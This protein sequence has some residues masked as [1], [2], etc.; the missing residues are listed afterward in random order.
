MQTAIYSN[1]NTGLSLSDRN[2]PEGTYCEGREIDISNFPG[3]LSSGYPAVAITAPSGGL[4][5]V[6]DICPDTGT[7]NIYFIGSTKIWQMTNVIND[8]WAANFDGS[9]HAYYVV[10][11]MTQGSKLLIYSSM[12]SST[13]IPR[14]FYTYNTASNGYLGFY[15]LTG[16]P[17]TNDTFQTLNDKSA[18][19]DMV[20][21]Q[22]VLW[23]ADGQY[24]NKFDGRVTTDGTYT[25]QALDLGNGWQITKLITNDNYLLICAWRKSTTTNNT[26]SRIFYWDGNSQTYNYSVNISD[27]KIV[28]AINNNNE[29]LV[30]TEG[31]QL[32]SVV[33]RLNSSGNFDVVKNMVTP[34]AGSNVKFVGV[35]QNAIGIANNRIIIGSNYLVWSLGQD[36]S[37]S[38]YSVCIPWGFTTPVVS[39]IIS[40]IKLTGLYD[41]IYIG[42]SSYDGN[43]TTYYI[44]K[45]LYD[46]S[47]STRATYRGNYTDLPQKGVA[48]YVKFYFQKLVS[49]DSAT[50]SV[51]TDYG[52]SNSIQQDT[53]IISF[54]LDGAVTFKKFDLNQIE[55]HAFRPVVGFTGGSVKISKIVFGYDIIND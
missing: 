24:V 17:P 39:G 15:N 49:G 3:Y 30:V 35:N 22:S 42:F 26:I 34:V 44:L 50:V 32:M 2:T 20:E 9:S 5:Q 54:A 28:T 27:N 48:N 7:A 52:T 37:S 8:S 23:I 45:V 6:F 18:P 31:R 51:D 47:G 38:P 4:E 25:T 13:I 33:R 16:T 41:K 11:N 36:D 14:L 40:S 55:C 19:H 21:W 12:V 29:I 1:F 43:S 10:P 46:L 53:G